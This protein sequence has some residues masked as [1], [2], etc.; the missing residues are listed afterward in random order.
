[1]LQ[2][3][4][5]AMQ[6]GSIEKYSDKFDGAVEVDETYIGGR[7]RYRKA[8]E[9]G[10]RKGPRTGKTA[11][12]GFLERGGHVRLT[13]IDSIRKQPLQRH[14]RK[15]VKPGATVYTDELGSYKGLNQSYEHK[16]I[17]HAEAY[18]D[19]LI[20]T[21]GMENFWSLLKRSL[22]G[23][24]V[25]VEPYH[26]FRYLDEQAY[27]FNAR[28]GTDGERFHEVL[29]R[30]SGRRLTWD[31]VRDR[32]KPE[33]E[34]PY[35]PTLPWKLAR[36]GWGRSS[37]SAAPSYVLRVPSSRA[38]RPCL[39]PSSGPT[40]PYVGRPRTSWRA[41]ARGRRSP[42][43]STLRGSDLFSVSVR[44]SLGSR[45]SLVHVWGLSGRRGET[46]RAENRPRRGCIR[47]GFSLVFVAFGATATVLGSFLLD[48]KE[49]LARIGGVLIILMGLIFMGAIKVP[50]LYQE[51][52][53]HPTPRAG[54]WGSALL[55][56]AFA[57]GWTPCI[58]VTLGF[59]LTMAAGRGESGGALE[60]AVLLAI[61]SLGLGIPFIL[62]GSGV[63]RLTG[64]MARLRRHI[65]TVNVASGVIM[66][67]VGILFVTNQVFQISIWIQNNVTAL[68][69]FWT[70]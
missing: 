7:A 37:P 49:S 1:M 69:S 31:E 17:N 27:R 12:I 64:V 43:E 19:G 21:N 13:V 3:L 26:L 14:V 67:L 9:N 41:W 47:D 62:S 50:F 6:H 58:G 51:A 24:Y 44:A 45:L 39:R 70:L 48:N 32:N 66:V 11:V 8:I 57:F 53:F 5:L 30:V 60:G 22:S 63:S 42:V 34:P 40:A 2:R 55:G 33:P 20:H 23:T 25:K 16:V 28:K 29:G 35:Q 46:E 54:V 36:S 4:R 10:E 52:R 61:Y 38:R 65:R 56:G 18:V 15:H 68:R 59:V